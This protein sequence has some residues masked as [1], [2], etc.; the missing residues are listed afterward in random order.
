MSEEDLG[1]GLTSDDLQLGAVQR[2][3]YVLLGKKIFHLLLARLAERVGLE[4]RETVVDG[5]VH[6]R[7]P[8]HRAECQTADAALQLILRSCFFGGFFNI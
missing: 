3:T 8:G 7:N 1:S 5:Q 6:L 2:G 4:G